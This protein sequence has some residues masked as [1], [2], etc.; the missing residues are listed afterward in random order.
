MRESERDGK[1]NILLTLSNSTESRSMGTL[2][3]LRENALGQSADSL[4]LVIPS[5]ETRLPCRPLGTV[6]E[7][8]IAAMPSGS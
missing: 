2:S 3:R 1:K 5:E 7:A 6:L 8:A 4:L